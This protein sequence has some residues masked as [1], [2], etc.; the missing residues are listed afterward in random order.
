V[1]EEQDLACSVCDNYQQAINTPAGA[2]CCC[3]QRSIHYSLHISRIDNGETKTRTRISFDNRLFDY[4]LTSLPGT[5]SVSCVCCARCVQCVLSH[6]AHCQ[7]VVFDVPGVS[8]VCCHTRHTVNMSCLMCQVC[9]VCVVTPGTLSVCRVCAVPGVSSVCCHTRHT[10]NMS[11]MMCQVCPV[12]VATPGGD[13][14]HM[15]D[16]LISHLLVDHHGGQ[17]PDANISFLLFLNI[18]VLTEWLYD[19]RSIVRWFF[20]FPKFLSLASFWNLLGHVAILVEIMCHINV[21]LTLV[22]TV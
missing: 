1:G 8:S 16:D 3:S 20:V 4:H 9:P 13:P 2:F 5:L 6:P 12:C 17:K 15:T 19:S 10:V 11:C 18:I 22:F 21:R 14:N 7:Y